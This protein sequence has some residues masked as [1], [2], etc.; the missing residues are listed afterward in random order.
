MEFGARA[1]MW[2]TCAI[3]IDLFYITK[4]KYKDASRQ[5]SGTAG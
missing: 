2:Y 1:T 4:E 5:S 3:K